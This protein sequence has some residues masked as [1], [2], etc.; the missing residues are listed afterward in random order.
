[1]KA[2]VEIPEG[3]RVLTTFNFG[4]Y[5][6]WRLPAISE[7]IDSRGVFPDSAALPDVPQVGNSQHVGP[8]RSATLAVVPVDYPV[9]TLLDS[10]PEWHRVGT[11]APAPWARRAARVG[12]WAKREWLQLHALPASLLQ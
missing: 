5:L 8:W 3:T 10:A 7:S 11:S 1:L 12:L 4:S 9:A 2:N 6:K